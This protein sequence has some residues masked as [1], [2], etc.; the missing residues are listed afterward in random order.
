MQDP[1][2]DVYSHACDRAISDQALAAVATGRARVRPV[3]HVYE[4]DLTENGQQDLP[5]PHNQEDLLNA[6]EAKC[7]MILH[8]HSVIF[9]QRSIKE[10]SACMMLHTPS[11]LIY[12]FIT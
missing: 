3:R 6:A 8:P 11:I 2:V 7:E 4:H 1:Q 10:H 5:R 12:E 9:I